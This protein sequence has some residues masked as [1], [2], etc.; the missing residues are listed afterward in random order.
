MDLPSVSGTDL[1]SWSY[2]RLA[3][4]FAVLSETI[5]SLEGALQLGP[6]EGF[7]TEDMTSDDVVRCGR[8]QDL[9]IREMASRKD[10]EDVAA[11][12]S[13]DLG[14]LTR[15]LTGEAEA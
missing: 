4:E 5:R 11:D 9:I 14:D 2:E 10:Q 15:R 8:A 12:L 6:V 13:L 3:G 1:R 7:S